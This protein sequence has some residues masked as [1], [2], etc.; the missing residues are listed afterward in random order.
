MKNCLL[1]LS[2][3]FCMIGFSQSYTYPGQVWVKLKPSFTLMEFNMYLNNDV[4]LDKDWQ[5][6]V[7]ELKISSIHHPFKS[8]DADVQRIYK[9]H[10]SYQIDP[11]FASAEINKLLDVAWAEPCQVYKTFT[12]PNDLDN[13]QS[14]Y[15]NMLQASAAWTMKGTSLTTIAIIDDAIQSDHPDLAANIYTNPKEIPGNTIDDDSNGYVDDSHG[16]DVAASDTDVRPPNSLALLMLHGTHTAGIAGGVTD[17]T[18]GMASISYNTVRILPVKSSTLPNILTHVEEGI[19]YAVTM[20]PDVISMSFGGS[21]TSIIKTMK[22]LL[23]AAHKNG[24]MCVAAAGNEGQE[25][26]TY[27]AAFDHVI[28]VGSVSIGDTVSSFSNYGNF[29]DMMAP[30]EKIYSTL[31][32]I[33]YPYGIQSG[34]SMSAPMVAGLVGL[35]RSTNPNLTADQLEL[36]LK[37]SCD[38]IDQQN[39][40]LVGKVGAGRVNALRAM[41][42]AGR[43]AIQAVEGGENIAIFPNPSHGQFN[44][45]LPQSWPQ[46]TL[47]V[48]DISGKEILADQLKTKNYKLETNLPPGFYFFQITSNTSSK[49][50][51]VVVD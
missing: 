4:A 39:P 26:V 5:R 24:I 29:I 22:T 35:M 47:K 34:T 32:G 48:F 3:C 31:P 44:I 8:H 17:N 2:F 18:I 13:K 20:H 42:C 12:T 38:N 11:A 21:D 50:L 16:Y 28:A 27:P 33:S 9:V 23:E 15:F 36:C 10:F 30:G 7:K 25:I 51:K 14:G 41:E 49:V 40:T 37:Y 1:L 46:A 45:I 43:N 19:D 6:L